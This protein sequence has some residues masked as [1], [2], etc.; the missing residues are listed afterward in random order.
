AVLEGVVRGI[1]EHR[2]DVTILTLQR[3]KRPTESYA[4]FFAR[5]G[6]RAVALRTVAN[7][8]DVCL[9]IAREGIP[10]VV[11]S[12]RFDEP[13]V[14][15]IDGASGDE[16]A[17]AVE[18]LIELGHRRIA[19]TMHNVP[20]RDHEDRLNGY[21]SGLRAGGI[22]FSD[23]LVWRQPSSLSGGATAL[24]LAMTYSD[25]PTALVAADPLLA[26]GAVRRAHELGVK[27]P[28]D[29]S[30]VGFDDG[31]MRFC[32]YPTMSCVCQNAADVGIAAGR[33]LAAAV[34]GETKL[35]RS[36][37]PTYFEVNGTT[38]P[39]LESPKPK[40]SGSAAK[41]GLVKSN[42]GER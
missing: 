27:V 32:V 31:D 11:I 36:T 41:A 21:K 1:S 9:Q 20:D 30:I 12:E 18:Y 29:M 10:H 7:T 24:E 8:R 22:P 37:L 14:C 42:G 40:R 16:T 4:Q 26:I 23:K 34:S 38:G 39:P 28:G 5:K 25:R 3:D 17:R 2:L 19:F 33:F 35:I 13:E 6:V 15:Y